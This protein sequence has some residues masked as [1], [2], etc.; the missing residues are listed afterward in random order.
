MSASRSLPPAVTT[1][2]RARTAYA[3]ASTRDQR[4]DMTWIP[5]GTFRMGSADFYPEERPVHRVTVAERPLVAADYPDADPALLVPGSAVFQ[6]TTGPVDLHD[7]RN[8]WEYV[9]GACWH[10]PDGPGRNY[11][12]L[13]EHPVT[14]AS[15]ADAEAYA[16]W[17][18]KELPTEAEWEFAARGGLAGKPFVW[19]DQFRPNGKWMANTHQGHFPNQDTGADGYTGLA[20]V[21]KFPAN[22]YG[23][24]DMAGNVSEWTDSVVP[25]SIESEKVGV[26]RGA[27]FKTNSEEH[28]VLTF[29][30]RC[31]PG[32]PAIRLPSGELTLGLCGTQQ[33]LAA[34]AGCRGLK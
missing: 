6:A 31:A 14:Q 21:A 25:G 27:N 12:G 2:Q 7:Y 18:G 5:A 16:T 10:R 19:G 24:Y 1:P 29:R 28:G 4:P 15:Y 20:P 13:G 3:G 32:S 34:S 33:D 22:G 30:G 11:R 9:P 17:A 26:I 23:L 8:W